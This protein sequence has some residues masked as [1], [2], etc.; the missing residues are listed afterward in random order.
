MIAMDS[1]AAF[2]LD[3]Y[4]DSWRLAIE[5]ELDRLTVRRQPETLWDGMRYS[6]QAGGKRLRPL[7]T[8]ATLEALGQDPMPALPAACALELIHTQSLI[9]D[10]LPAMDDD[11][12]RRG[13]PTNHKVFGEAQAILAGDAMLAWAFAVIAGPLNK[14]YPAERCLAVARE[15]AEATVLGMVSGQA[16]DIASEGQTISAETLAYIHTHK[17]GA[18]IRAAVRTGAV[19]S[20]ATVSDSAALDRY[21]DALGLAFQIADDILDVTKTA[22]E[23]GKTPGKDEAAD[24]ATYV[25]MYGLDVAHQRLQQAG[26]DAEEALVSFDA[27]AL[28]LRSLARYVV[29]QVN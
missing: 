22:A 13:K 24:K 18:L 28:P 29:N 21:A 2:D 25:K 9:H 23:L 7:L 17:T 8:V 4:W 14:V 27:S 20:G 26:D 3:T 5:S 10:D 19:L 11:D 16:V 1:Q 12:L 6:L 15:L